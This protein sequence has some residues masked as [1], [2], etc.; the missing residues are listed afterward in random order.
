M[1]GSMVINVTSPIWVTSLAWFLRRADGANTWVRYTIDGIQQPSME[2]ITSNEGQFFEQKLPA[3]VLLN[4]GS[5]TIQWSCGISGTGIFSTT[6]RP[7]R[8]EF[9]ITTA[10][11]HRMWM[12][13]VVANGHTGTETIEIDN[14]IFRGS[15]P[16]EIEGSIV[17]GNGK[18]IPFTGQSDD[19]LII[20]PGLIDLGIVS[21]SI[22]GGQQLVRSTTRFV[23][24]GEDNTILIDDIFN[25]Q[26]GDEINIRLHFGATNLYTHTD[27]LSEPVT[28]HSHTIP[29]SVFTAINTARTQH[30][31]VSIKRGTFEDTRVLTYITITRPTLTTVSMS[32][33]LVDL[34]MTSP[35]PIEATWRI[36]NGID[37]TVTGNAT[38]RNILDADRVL[39]TS[40]NMLATAI[41]TPFDFNSIFTDISELIGGLYNVVLSA[42]VSHAVFGSFTT[43][44]NRNNAFTCA[45]PGVPG[46]SITS[47]SHSGRYVGAHIDILVSTRMFNIISG[48]QLRY[49]L[50]SGSSLVHGHTINLS[51]GSTSNTYTIPMGHFANLGIGMY[52]IMVATMRGGFA[53][54]TKTLDFEIIKPPTLHF[55]GI[56]PDEIHL[57]IEDFMDINVSMIVNGRGINSIQG[58]FKLVDT[59]LTTVV[60]VNI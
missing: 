35:H 46:I 57:P 24:V 34:P 29:A 28:S 7:V 30:I 41:V 11:I 16:V 8:P 32:N 45:Y 25:A 14:N 10:T 39:L 15:Y 22:A 47:S 9:T 40:E 60:G 20:E 50:R 53:R 36:T 55:I 44:I 21:Q 43:T 3:P 54:Q 33:T 6:V 19:I 12:E 42:T 58:V 52:S 31:T 4:V 59:P 23:G 56:N 37:C 51:T 1:S 13:Y 26:T 49:E 5:R 2:I 38:V 27:I 48:D 17:A 18:N